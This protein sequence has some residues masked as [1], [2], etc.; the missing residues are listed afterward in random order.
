MDQKQP[1]G[2]RPWYNAKRDLRLNTDRGLQVVQI[3]DTQ[4]NEYPTLVIGDGGTYVDF[5][6]N[7]TFEK[8]SVVFQTNLTK[9]LLLSYQEI[10]DNMYTGAEKR[11]T[12]PLKREVDKRGVASGGCMPCSRGS[13]S[14]AR[15][16][17]MRRASRDQYVRH[18]R[19]ES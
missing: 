14:R 13:D 16:Y 19:H 1:G 15:A 2:S 11:S 8:H 17:D 10:I 9:R 5:N 4:N 7:G 6:G 3:G 18:S 12:N